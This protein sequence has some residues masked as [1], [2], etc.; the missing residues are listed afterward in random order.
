MSLPKRNIM[1]AE[2]IQYEFVP[3]GHETFYLDFNR[4]KIDKQ[5]T[6]EIDA[7]VQA[8]YVILN[9]ERKTYVIYPNEMGIKTSDLYGKDRDFVKS[10]L[11]KRISDALKIDDRI[12]SAESFKFEDIDSE[13]LYCSFIANTIY[14]S[15][16]I[17]GVTFN[18]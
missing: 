16:K 12:I 8:I 11:K 6:D 14:G 5:L 17:K 9:V 13:S 1:P 4:K 10:V 15:K 7:V 18:V 2:S 3:L